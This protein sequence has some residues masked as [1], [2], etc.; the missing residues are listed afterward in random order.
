LWN[1]YTGTNP[2]LRADAELYISVNSVSSIDKADGVSCTKENISPTSAEIRYKYV[3]S[4][5]VEETAL[6]SKTFTMGTKEITAK[7]T[8][9]YVVRGGSDNSVTIT[10]PKNTTLWVCKSWD[11]SY[12]GDARFANNSWTSYEG[13]KDVTL[14]NGY[15]FIFTAATNKTGTSKVKEQTASKLGMTAYEIVPTEEKRQTC[16]A[17][18]LYEYN[19]SMEIDWGGAAEGGIKVLKKLDGS[20]DTERIAGLSFFLY[21]VKA[22]GDATETDNRIATYTL[23]TDGTC[24]VKLSGSADSICGTT[25]NT[26]TVEESDNGYYVSG[27]PEGWYCVRESTEDAKKYGVSLA[28][29]KYTEIT[30]S[31]KKTVTFTFKNSSNY[32]SLIKE[33][34]N[35]DAADDKFYNM[36]GI[37]YT[38]SIVS[39]NKVEPTDY[40]AIAEFVTDEN[41]VGYVDAYDSTKY[42]INKS[43][44]KLLGVPTGAWI[45][46]EETSV[47]EY[48]NIELNTTKIWKKVGD[49]GAVKFT[50]TDTITRSK[51]QVTK[52]L[53]NSQLDSSEIDYSA[54]EGLEIILYKFASEA[55]YDT[56]NAKGNIKGASEV[57]TYKVNKKGIGIPVELTEYGKEI[58]AKTTYTAGTDINTSS[59]RNFYNL[60]LGYYVLAEDKTSANSLGLSTADN[61]YIELDNKDNNTTDHKGKV[62]EI[63]DSMSG[64]TLEKCF[65]TP[66]MEVSGCYDIDGAEY[67]IYLTTGNNVKPVTSTGALDSSK[68]IGTFT[69]DDRGRG[70]VTSISSG[71]TRQMKIDNRYYMISGIPIGSWIYVTERKASRG[72]SLDSDRWYRN[73]TNAASTGVTIIESVEGSLMDPFRVYITKQDALA[74]DT[75]GAG[76]LA[77]AIFRVRYYN[78]LYSSASYLPSTATRTWYFET[79]KSGDE[80]AFGFDASYLTTNSKYKSDELYYDD[81]GYASIPLGT[82]VID[83]VEAPTG[84]TISGATM[85]DAATGDD[86]SLIYIVADDTLSGATATTKVVNAANNTEIGSEIIVNEIS[87]RG[88]I[89]FR[90]VALDTKEPMAGVPFRITSMTTGESHI[91]VTDKNGI[92]DTSAIAHSQNTNANDNA[93]DGEYNSCG[94]WFYGNTDETGTIDDEQ[95]ALAFDTYTIEELPSAANEGYRLVAT[96]TVTELGSTVNYVD[97]YYKYDLGDI[98]NVHEPKIYTKVY[99]ADTDSQLVPADSVVDFT[100]TVNYEW[101]TAGETYTVKGVVIDKSTGKPYQQA[102]GTYCMGRKVF[103]TDADYEESP[104]EKSGSVVVDYKIDTTDLDDKDLVVYEYLFEGNSEGNLVITEAGDISLEGVLETNKGNKIYHADIEDENQTIHVPTIGTQLTDDTYHKETQ[105]CESVTLIDTVEY[106]NLIP[107]K[108]YEMKGTLYNKETEKALLDADGNEITASTSFVASAPAGTVEVKFTFNAAIALK[109]SE[110]VVA[111]EDCYSNDG[112][113]KIATHADINDADQ[114][115]EFPHIHTQLTGNTSKEHYELYSDDMKLTDNVAYTNLPVGEELTFVGYLYNAR[116]G[117]ILKDSDGEVKSERKVTLSE[118]AEGSLDMSYNFNGLEAL[119]IND[120][121]TVDSVVCFEYVYGSDGRLLASHEDLSDADQTVDIPNGHTEAHD[122]KT[123]THT[124]QAEADCSITDIVYYEDLIPGKEYSIE[125]KLMVKNTG[126]ALLVDGKK[127]TAEKTFTPKKSSGYVTLTF[128]FDSSALA[129]ESIVVFEDCYKDGIKVF[130]H[131]DITDADQTINFPSAGTMAVNAEDGSKELKRNSDIVLLDTVKYNNLTVGDRYVIKGRVID[132]ETGDT[133]TVVSG[134]VTAEEEFTASTASGTIDVEFNFNTEGL[135]GKSLVVFEEIYTY[136]P[137]GKLVLVIEHSNPDDTDQTVSVPKKPDTPNEDTPHP[138]TGDT[139]KPY[140]AT[141]VLL[142]C[143]A[144]LI[145]LLVIRKKKR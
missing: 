135:D 72:C 112:K 92:V 39:G 74:G 125:G 107:G 121:G 8:H 63:T 38:V 17:A 102:D 50:G 18:A 136:N 79:K 142:V 124:S 106:S 5:D 94:I 131:S 66:D 86:V 90:K 7:R 34:E 44:T 82:V 120:D 134:S 93:A 139:A 119:P 42:S 91:V 37:R 22:S 25:K 65:E 138:S 143:I 83:E 123:G 61:I 15:R 28:D 137:S 77:G 145:V 27:L 117:K 52:K 32:V 54:A 68:K 129:G 122:N 73:T 128:T 1:G 46:A 6:D 14:K 62:Y 26:I 115:I 127:V 89:V 105:Y 53:R 67:D 60:P 20:Y 75:T 80:Y 71:Y 64:I 99:C 16:V 81:V 58:G 31:S 47:P 23:G 3:Y 98:T 100:D 111:F 12:S 55:D 78:N 48:S 45:C 109:W 36:E 43:G 104:Y 11:N 9:L 4:C 2:P 21:K 41:G 133:F 96:A 130:T 118:A 132:K 69:T 141:L 95:G 35:Q 19:I 84:Y 29:N 49:D 76:S 51:I 114:T 140:T 33:L 126:K 13:G 110:H 97:G 116:T 10:V 103:T 88:D 40:D 87:N 113:I 85:T 144:A 59:S 108:S 30:S 70:Y 56:A 24:T 101:L 57:G